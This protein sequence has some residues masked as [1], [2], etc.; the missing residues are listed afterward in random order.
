MTKREV[1]VEYA[2]SW[3]GRHY[4]WAGDDP[5]GV[6]C[7]GYAVECLKG[8]GVLSPNVDYTAAGLFGLYKDNQKNFYKRSYLA[9][10]MNQ[11]G[12]VIHVEILIDGYHTIGASGGGR[13]KFDLY[14]TITT[15]RVLKSFYPENMSRIQFESYED[16]FIPTMVKRQLY[17]L[18]ADQQN[19][20]I[21]I[22][23]LRYRGDN[24][25]VCDP[26]GEEE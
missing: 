25:V 8:V 11:A 19:A 9:F 2:M 6:D 10:W 18:Q 16:E 3:I 5:S 7:S 15:D 21:K 17:E 23:P 20:F 1:F 26:F 13:P 14:K 4:V 12:S 22:R 24:F